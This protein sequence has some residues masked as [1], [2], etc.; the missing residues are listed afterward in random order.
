MY[1]FIDPMTE[2]DIEQVQQIERRSFTTTWSPNTYRH[3]LRTPSNSRYIVARTSPVPPPPRAPTGRVRRGI[4][5]SLFPAWFGSESDPMVSACPIVG[6]GG[7]WISVDE[8]HITTIAVMPE[9]R[10]RGIGELVLNGLI[11]QA[12]ALNADMLTLEVRVSNTSAQQLYLKYGFHPS[13]TRPR[14][15]TDNS[16]DALIMWTE[17]IRSPSYQE[18]IQRLRELLFNRLRQD[19]AAPPPPPGSDP[20][21]SPLRPSHLPE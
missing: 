14:Y 21:S 15:Y 2:S 12:L 13:G 9:Y 8:G 10:G 17:P 1:Y 16:E 6:Y 5:A 19:A 7:L 20:T 18:R 3:E 4:L 11:D